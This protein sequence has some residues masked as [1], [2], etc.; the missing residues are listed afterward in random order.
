MSRAKIVPAVLLIL[1]ITNGLA[2]AADNLLRA[3]D[4][5]SLQPWQLNAHLREHGQVTLLPAEQGVRVSNPVID[6]DGSLYQDVATDGH[7]QFAWSA[8]IRGENMMRASLGFVSLDAAGHTLAISTPTWVS[9]TRWM[10][11]TGILQVPPDTV[12]LRVL[13]SVL[14]G[15]C[16]FANLE[17]RKAAAQADSNPPRSRPTPG[18]GFTVKELTVAR[19]FWELFCDDLDGDGRPE[20]V[21]CDV[22]GAVTVRQEGGPAT[23]TFAAGA[24]VYQF[25]AADL[26]GDGVK[27]ILLSSV[28]PKIPV[29][30]V[31]LR[32]KAVRVFGDS[33]GPERIAAADMD[34]DGRPEVAVSRSNDLL[35]LGMAAGVVLYDEQGRKLWEKKEPLRT[36]Q[37][38]DLVP[39]AG[40]SLVVG[41]PGVEFRIYDRE[42]KM[43]RQVARVKGQLEQFQVA[44]LDG[45]GT[46]EIVASFLQDDRL[47]LICR[48]GDTTLWEAAIPGGVLGSEGKENS[49]AWHECADFDP[50]S[51]G[52]ETVVVGTHGV[53]MF[54]AKGVMTYQ[55]KSRSGGEYWQKWTPGGINSLDIACWH[56]PTPHLYL[57]SSRYRHQAYYR[58]QYGGPDQF[59]A[60][61]APD[62]E[63]HLD[64]IYTAAKSQPALPVKGREKVKVFIASSEFGDASLATLREYRASLDALETPSLEYLVMYEAS[65]LLGH[66]R[67]FKLTTDQI[68][69]RAR[70]LEQARIPFGYFA[71]HGGQVWTTREAMR[72]SKEAAP[73]MFRFVYVAENLQTLYGPLYPDMLQWMGE[74]L[75]F[76]AEQ[77]MKMIFKEK[78]DAWGLLLSDPEVGR[79]LFSPAHREAVVPIWSTNQPYQPEIQLGGMLGLKLAGWCRE[80]GMS[81]Q[82][83][84]WHEW[85]SYPR[86]IRDVSAAYVCPADIMLRLELT[87]L[88]LGGTW[89]HIEDGQPYL[90]ADF[91]DGVAP[92][93]RR[94]RELAYELIR[95]NLLTPGATP[96]NLNQA[97]LLR[98]IHPAFEKG[99]A[100]RRKVASPYY[101]R[102]TPELRQG[103]I[104]ARYLF[105]T[106]S[107]ESFPRLAYDM[108]WNVQTCF[109]QTP[110]GWLPVLPADVAVHPNWL[111]I[112]T[113]GERVQLGGEWQTA[114]AA[115]ATV[116]GVIARGAKHIPLAAPG[117]SLIIQPVPGEPDICVALLM[118]PG[119]LA[120]TGVVTTVTSTKRPMQRVTDLVSGAPVEFTGRSFPVRIEPGA[121]RLLR[122]ELDPSAQN[123]PP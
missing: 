47:N 76:C 91:R 100:T 110:H 30:A 6:L 118:D 60:F 12:R 114:S 59:S 101:N 45:D 92:T 121:F 71:A 22:D 56:G 83:W 98:S 119:Y 79:I 108:D 58:L 105:E 49:G 67:G 103:F 19:P 29:R 63:K 17:L 11:F 81:T 33:C 39:A 122:I 24:L 43:R 68:V 10:D 57:S 66:E 62:Q 20:I 36:F 75:D 64:E 70:L 13:L 52:K 31:N 51:P 113:D 37:F 74:M 77:D 54:D 23:L 44:D 89:I 18:Q 96:A 65:D 40:K 53:A 55:S 69:A 107:E 73:T 46:G 87:G 48:R 50:A 109:P 86:G 90:R 9:G 115:A 111:P 97:V 120:P 5:E 82:F 106:Y 112:I 94:H 34:G 93:A 123:F 88:A 72:R 117:V 95:K 25:A 4:F 15:K 1:L 35:G 41:G 78:H 3:G 2:G 80:F 99:K 61:E 116:A 42:G 8:R 16:S 7:Q 38:G 14:D 26:D 84:N 21:G 32:G 27:E 28:D 104:P 85:G 102:N